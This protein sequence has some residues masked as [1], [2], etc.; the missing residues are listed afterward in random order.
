MIWR[1]GIGFPQFQG[2]S[3]TLQGPSRKALLAFQEAGLQG[4][5]YGLPL[6]AMAAMKAEG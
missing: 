4:G 3:S 6:L 2:F 1:T 5:S